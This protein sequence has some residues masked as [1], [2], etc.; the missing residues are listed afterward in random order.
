MLSASSPVGAAASGEGQGVELKPAAGDIPSVELALF[1]D[2]Q[3][4]MKEKLVGLEMEKREL[5][6]SGEGSSW[7]TVQCSH[8]YR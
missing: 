2:A 3:D 1:K 6:V 5:V 8:D 7:L 4:K